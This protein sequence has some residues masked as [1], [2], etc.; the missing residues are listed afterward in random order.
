[1]T[2]TPPNRYNELSAED[3]FRIDRVV[4]HLASTSGED[5]LRLQLMLDVGYRESVTR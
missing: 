3:R 2:D 1:M 4:N 5:H